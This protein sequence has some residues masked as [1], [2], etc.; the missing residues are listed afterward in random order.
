[1]IF[2]HS[3]KLSKRNEDQPLPP[4][5][6]NTCQGRG[7]SCKHF[8][9]RG[10]GLSTS[11]SKSHPAMP[12][13]AFGAQGNSGVARWVADE[14]SRGILGSGWPPVRRKRGH[15]SFPTLSVSSHQGVS[16][17]DISTSLSGPS[18]AASSRCEGRDVF[19]RVLLRRGADTRKGV[20]LGAGRRLGCRAPYP[21]LVVSQAAA[22]FRDPPPCPL[23]SAFRFAAAA[24]G[25]AKRLDGN[26]LLFGI[27]FPFGGAKMSK[28]MVTKG[29]PAQNVE[30]KN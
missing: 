30:E 26:V 16:N 21:P 3:L 7:V 20:D 9:E 15:L 27:F 29:W 1:M 2:G 13:G 4:P 11:L 23:T 5:S 24:E 12:S 18:L 14:V 8:A 19:L 6:F 17:G 22:F 25:A 28:K 10:W